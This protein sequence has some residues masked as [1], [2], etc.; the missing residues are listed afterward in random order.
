MASPKSIRI[1]YPIAPPGS[2]RAGQQTST[3]EC[4]K[5]EVRKIP[6][7]QTNMPRALD[8]DGATTSVVEELPMHATELPP[9][10]T[11]LQ[12]Y[13]AQYPGGDVKV[14]HSVAA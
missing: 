13:R 2:L 11:E 10:L 4:D 3:W 7:V 8:S 1:I 14:S 5:A 9:R 6:V 12:A